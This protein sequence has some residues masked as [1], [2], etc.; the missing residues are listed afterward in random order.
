MAERAGGIR[1]VQRYIHPSARA[2]T[3]AAIARGQ[4]VPAVLFFRW[5]G[6]I[7]DFFVLGVLGGVLAVVVGILARLAGGVGDRSLV[8]LTLIA[9]WFA[10]VVGYYTVTEGLWGRTLGQARH[11]PVVVDRAP[12][13]WQ[14]QV[15]SRTALRLVEVNPFLSA[16]SRPAIAV[17]GAA[18]TSSASAT[19]PPRP[20][21][22]R[23]RRWPR[24]RRR[25][26][27]RRYD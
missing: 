27:G 7:I 25:A 17:H 22:C 18:S 26:A 1:L 14:P 8:G 6:T 3:P 11:R 21:S 23:S 4:T 24:R 16:A 9:V 12:P 19:W 5:L 15:L 10:E 2:V 20:M 13:G